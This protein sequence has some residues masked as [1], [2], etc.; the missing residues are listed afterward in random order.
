MADMDIG[1]EDDSPETQRMKGL[2]YISQLVRVSYVLLFTVCL[3]FQYSNASRTVTN[4]CLLLT[5][6]TSSRSYIYVRMERLQVLVISLSIRVIMT[7]FTRNLKLIVTRTGRQA[8][9]YDTFW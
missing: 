3:N 9:G 4:R 1:D 5:W 8:M 2:K 6:R 7:V